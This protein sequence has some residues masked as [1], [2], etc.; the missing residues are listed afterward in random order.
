VLEADPVLVEAV[1]LEVPDI[2]IEADSVSIPM[3]LHC[4]SCLG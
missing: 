4:G 2:E 3:H 1:E